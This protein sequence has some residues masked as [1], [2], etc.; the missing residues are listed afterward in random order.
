MVS[1][2]VGDFLGDTSNTLMTDAITIFLQDCFKL[3]NSKSKLIIHK[4]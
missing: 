4:I 2:T 3:L 1:K